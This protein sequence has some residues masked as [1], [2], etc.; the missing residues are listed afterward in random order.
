MEISTLICLSSLRSNQANMMERFLKSNN[1][2]I[3]TFVILSKERLLNPKPRRKA[4]NPTTVYVQAGNRI[5]KEKI[6]TNE[7]F[8]G[9]M[10][11]EESGSVILI[12]NPQEFDE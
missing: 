10:F 2:S 3:S 6:N 5:D 12:P 11:E 7:F 1:I 8:F 9:Y 4:N